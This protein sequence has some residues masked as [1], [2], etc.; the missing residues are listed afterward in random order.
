MNTKMLFLFPLL[1]LPWEASAATVV[2]LPVTPYRSLDDSP[3]KAAVRAGDALK[4]RFG[5]CNEH[6][7]RLP[8]GFGVHDDFEDRDCISPWL[9][10]KSGEILRGA[11]VDADDRYLDGFGTHSSEIGI[12]NHSNLKS[13]WSLCPPA[14]VICRNGLALR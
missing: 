4:F 10:L 3:W 7:D 8:S 11:S 5:D 14:A 9:R 12:R 6:A 2:V 1:T 13:H